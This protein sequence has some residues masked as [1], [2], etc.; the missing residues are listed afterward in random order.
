MLYIREQKIHYLVSRNQMVANKFLRQNN[1]FRGAY[2][3]RAIGAKPEE[4]NP[5]PDCQKCYATAGQIFANLVIFYAYI[6]NSVLSHENKDFP[7]LHYYHGVIG[8]YV[9]DDLSILV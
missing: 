6:L 4:S 1:S 8:V 3:G 5:L 7:M 2:W 9:K